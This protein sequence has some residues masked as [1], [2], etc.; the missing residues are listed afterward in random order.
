VNTGDIPRASGGWMIEMARLAGGQL[1]L[2]RKRLMTKVLV[3]LLALGFAIVVGFGVLEY[4][5]FEN[6]A[7]FS[8]ANACP[9][10]VADQTA[11]PQPGGPPRC[12]TPSPQEQQQVEEARQRVIAAERTNLTFPTSLGSAGGYAQFMGLILLAILAGALVGGEYAYGTQRLAFA[13]GAGRG[14]V[15]AAQTGALAVLALVTA[16]LTLLLGVLSGVTVG[17]A[18]GGTV[19]GLTAAGVGEVLLYWLVISLVLF[20]GMLIALFTATLGRSTAAG[21]GGALGYQLLQLIGAG[22]LGALGGS[23]PGD[24]GTWLTRSQF[25][26]IGPSA[27]L[28]LGRVA[29]APLAL[30]GDDGTGPVAPGVAFAVLVGYCVLMVGLSYL[31]VRQ[32]DVTT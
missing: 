13:R 17:P 26:F 11:T 29:H 31:L 20:A 16:A 10:V 7:I 24:T 27:S 8:G 25:L 2:V 28:V 30:V 21:I 5:L 6:Q 15:L 22:L 32:R 3:V 12:V 14:Q 23:I 4:A 1:L 18:V 19:S 9:T